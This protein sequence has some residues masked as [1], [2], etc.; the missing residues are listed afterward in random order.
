MR[1]ESSERGAL[2]NNECASVCGGGPVG[3]QPEMTRERKLSR[4]ISATDKSSRYQL[5][6]HSSGL[7]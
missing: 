2:S 4:M 5:G 7:R 1:Q 3:G 6:A